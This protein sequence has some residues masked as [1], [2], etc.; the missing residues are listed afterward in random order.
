MPA[1]IKSVDCAVI[2]C[3]TL[4]AVAPLIM[5]RECGGSK[6]VS[7]TPTVLATPFTEHCRA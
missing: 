7:H 2:G 3:A 6:A 1:R 5:S 4:A